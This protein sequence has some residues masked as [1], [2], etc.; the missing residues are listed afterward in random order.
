MQYLILI[1]VV[2]AI[3]YYAW[4]YL[5]AIAGIFILGLAI[6]KFWLKKLNKEKAENEATRIKTSRVQS[7]DEVK[8]DTPV[9]DDVTEVKSPDL[10]GNSQYNEPE[11]Q[12]LYHPEPYVS[13]Q[14]VLPQPTLHKLRR[15][16]YDFVV[17][18]IET[19]GLS[20]VTNKIIQISAIKVKEDKIADHFNCF[21]NPH[22]ELPLDIVYLTGI[23]NEDLVEAA[24]IDDVMT[25]FKNF[26][27]DLP[28]VG[29]NIFKFDIPFIQANGFDLADISG[30]DTWKLAQTKSFSGE[31]KNLKLPTLKKY[32]GISNQSHN[33]LNDCETNLKVYQNL[34]DDKLDPVEPDTSDIPK[35]F[36]GLRFAITGQFMGTS[37]EEIID[38]IT[39]HG[40]RVTKAVS[41]LTDYLIDGKQVELTEGVHSQKELSAL[42]RQ[43]DGGKIKILNYDQFEHLVNQPQTQAV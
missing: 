9:I 31:L 14:P 5:L 10:T 32:Y 36:A 28:L 8:I 11:Q 24:D 34:R 30:I 37:R 43:K 29:H 35:N 41:G 26:V 12:T 33:A 7:S 4:P 42:Q 21:V 19:T 2:I 27:E 40:G 15:K 3:L 1:V 17:F 38:E 6:R 23:Q 39:L 22:I 20:K 13:S 16:L 25:L 18:D